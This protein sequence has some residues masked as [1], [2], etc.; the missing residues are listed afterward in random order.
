[1][2]LMRFIGPALVALVTATSMVPRAEAQTRT[3]AAQTSVSPGDIQ[4]LQD[5]ISEARRDLSQVRTRDSALASQL[6]AE[7]DDA[8]DDATYLKVKLR[9]HEP[10]AQS[11]YAD[12][13]DRVENIR[14]RARSDASGGY[15]P[16]P[17]GTVS[18]PDRRP[19][20]D[21]T[22]GRITGNVIPVG[23]EF[24]VR[25]QNPLSSKSNAVEDR[26]EATTLVDQ[27][28]DRGRVLV[29]ADR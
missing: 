17:S 4:R 19:A 21:S 11:E 2:A 6:Q 7:L 28:D 14:S 22:S 1:V 3:T 8:S 9:K 29:P 23:I 10:I 12:V 5:A 25:L 16:P 15:T 13:R 24:D 18:E 20:P 27:Q 26:F